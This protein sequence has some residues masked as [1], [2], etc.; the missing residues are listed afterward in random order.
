MRRGQGIYEG[1]RY[2]LLTQDGQRKLAYL[3]LAA[4]FL[5]YSHETGLVFK[6]LSEFEKVIF[7]NLAILFG[8]I[9][10]SDL[11]PDIMPLFVGAGVF[12]VAIGFGAQTLVRD[13]IVDF[14]I[15]LKIYLKLAT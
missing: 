11:G 5:M 12:G 6:K 7:S 10:L 4:Q 1:Q 15:V 8:L 13:F 2:R 9:A 3:L 14:T